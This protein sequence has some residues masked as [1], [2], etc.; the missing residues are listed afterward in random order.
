MRLFPEVCLFLFLAP[1]GVVAQTA[2]PDYP[3]SCFYAANGEEKEME[4]HAGC[5]RIDGGR[6]IPDPSHLARMDFG[7]DGLASVRV[8]RQVY[9]VRPDGASLAVVIYDNWTDNYSEGLVRGRREGKVAYFD[10]DFRM[11]IPSRYDWGWPFENGHALVCKGCAPK[12]SPD[13]EH[14]MVDG[15]LWGYIDKSGSEVVPVRFSRF[16]VNTKLK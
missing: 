6:L 14:V 1:C 3:I 2:S 15:G 4:E 10:R 7:M 5:A 12:R 8:G 16:E 11:V 13:N 9:Y